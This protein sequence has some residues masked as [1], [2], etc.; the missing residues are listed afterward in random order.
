[1][2]NGGERGG[3]L[4]GVECFLRRE[5]PLIEK[6]AQQ[7]LGVEGKHENADTCLPPFA[8][9]SLAYGRR[10]FTQ[11]TTQPTQ[12]TVRSRRPPDGISQESAFDCIAVSG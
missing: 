8:A 11:D 1:V 10:H 6:R 9:P 4:L 7:Q 12:E 2:D 5:L 3:N